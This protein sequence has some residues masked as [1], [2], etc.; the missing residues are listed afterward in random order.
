MQRDAAG[1]AGPGG[2]DAPGCGPL[3]PSPSETR[4]LRHRLLE[5]LRAAGRASRVDLSRE[6]CI[7]PASVTAV[8]GDLIAQGLIAE[9]ETA[10]DETIRGR[11]PVSLAVAPGAHAVAGMK[12]SDDLHTAVILDFAGNVLGES[13]LPVSVHRKSGAEVMC[14]VE[15]LLDEA[16]AAAGLPRAALHGLGL[17]LPGT[18]A[19]EN[20]HVMWSPLLTERDLPLGAMLAERLGMQV[21]LDNDANVLTLAELWFGAGRRMGDF[22]LVTIEHG[23]GMGLVIGNRLFRGASGF[24]LEL[25]HTKV[26]LDG[27]LCRCGQRGC[28]EAYVADYALVREARTALHGDRDTAISPRALLSHLFQEAESGNAAARS[29]FSRA[30]RHLA[31]GLSNIVQLFDPSLIIL[32]GGQVRFETLY[33]NDVI[34]EMRALTLDTGRTPRVEV[35]AWGD[36]VWARGAGAM[37][38]SVLTAQLVGEARAA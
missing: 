21:V 23:L 16:L 27:A 4:P 24:G 20:G 36:M 1:G 31:M 37:A 11:P 22:V 5:H 9:V 2:A 8:A 15:A 33:A 25:G 12:L 13:T 7:S 29:I 3:L 10:R 34:A 38:L 18:V 26:S 17:G 19:Y 14:E 30:G 6:L 28:L 32:A 35:N